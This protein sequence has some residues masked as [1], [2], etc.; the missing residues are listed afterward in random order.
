L[1]PE[2]NG[3]GAVIRTEAARAEAFVGLAGLLFLI[4]IADLELALPA[5]LKD[6][7]YISGL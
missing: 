6:A 7:K 4:G 3:I 2:I 1:Q 5:A